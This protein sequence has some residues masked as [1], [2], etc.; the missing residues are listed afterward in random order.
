MHEQHN[1]EYKQSWH[2]DHLKTIC[3]YANLQGGKLYIG[4]DDKGKTAG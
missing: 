1:I 2:E 3:A 4:K